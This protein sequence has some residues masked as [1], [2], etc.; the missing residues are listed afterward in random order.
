[1]LKKTQVYQY[2][3][4]HGHIVEYAGYDLP[5]WYEG[6]IAECRNVRDHSGIFDV[7]HMGRVIVEGPDAA[8]FL[9]HVTTNNVSGLSVNQGHYS[10]FCNLNGGII[11]DLTIFCLDQVR[12]LVVYNAANREKNWNWLQQNRTGYQVGLNDV[13]DSMAMFAVQGPRA[14]DVLRLVSGVDLENVD[15]YSATKATCEGVSCLL[16]RTGY[17]GEDGFEAYVFDTTVDNPTKALRVWEGLI[18]K[19]RQY[20][21]HPVGLGARDVLRLEAGMCL[22]GNDID[23]KTSPV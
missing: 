11:D 7:S 5:V 17:T 13:S 4:E 12:Y 16:T 10:L 2:H 15:R 22:Y 6:I 18:G 3:L 1:M 14:R 19:G 20:G 23:E 9:D 21:L 8:R